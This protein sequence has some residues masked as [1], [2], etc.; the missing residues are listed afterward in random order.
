MPSLKR[1]EPSRGDTVDLLLECHA[2]I[3]HFSALGV[4]LANA[5]AAPPSEVAETARQVRRYFEVALPLHVE[6]EEQ[7]IAPRL[8][9]INA[10]LD[11]AL[12][13][14]RD[15]H[16]LA[17]P[18]LAQLVALCSRLGEAPSELGAVQ[19]QLATTARNLTE[20][21]DAHLAAEEARIFPALRDHLDDAERTLITGEMR[22]RRE[23]RA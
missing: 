2:R 12:A 10:A 20:L 18:S 1:R 13:A 15:E 22:Q 3:R 16:A 23:V 6:D 9:G 17:E 8:V 21:F 14:M 5:V 11:D 4:R 7:S 19:A